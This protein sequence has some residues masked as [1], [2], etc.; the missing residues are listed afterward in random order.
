MLKKLLSLF[1]IL[2]L[3]LCSCGKQKENINIKNLSFSIDFIYNNSAY[4]VDTKVYENG[5]INFTVAKPENIKG[6]QIIC[7]GDIL[8]VDFLGIE[9]EY[10]NEYLKNSPLLKIQKAFRG[11]LNNES[12]IGFGSDK[13]I[14]IENGVE[15]TFTITELGIPIAVEF[16]NYKFE[17]K[18]ISWQ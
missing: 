8:K 2:S 17:F 16:E 1:L 6:M 10:R 9:R 4:S 5:D 15:Y 11:L 13:R 18:N 12:K 7:C 14:I 3:F